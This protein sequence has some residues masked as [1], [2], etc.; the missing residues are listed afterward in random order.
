MLVQYAIKIF[1]RSGKCVIWRLSKH[2]VAK[3]EVILLGYV[4][5]ASFYYKLDTFIRSYKICPSRVLY[6]KLIKDYFSMLPLYKIG[7]ICIEAEQY[8]NDS[9]FQ[10]VVDVIWQC[11]MCYRFKGRME[12]GLGNDEAR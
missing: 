7:E 8:L 4:E 5:F 2:K 3:K 6:V 12:D 11:V 10:V 9:D 1:G